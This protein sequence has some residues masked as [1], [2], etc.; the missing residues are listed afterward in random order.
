MLVAFMDTSKRFI[1]SVAD[2]SS[3]DTKVAS[4]RLDMNSFYD[5]LSQNNLYDLLDNYI[6]ELYRP[7]QASLTQSQK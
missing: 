7:N 6:R 3:G 1:G 5:E 2:R 4:A